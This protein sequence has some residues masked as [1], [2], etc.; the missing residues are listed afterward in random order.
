MLAN[1]PANGRKGILLLDELQ[2]FLIFPLGSQGHISLNIDM[3][4]T[5]H[6]ARRSFPFLN[7]ECARDCITAGAGIFV[8]EHD[9]CLRI[10]VDGPLRTRNHTFWFRALLARNDPGIYCSMGIG[11]SAVA[12]YAEVM[13]HLV[14]HS[15]GSVHE[16]VVV[17]TRHNA[18]FTPNASIQI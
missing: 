16:F 13:R 5:L 2:G 15:F 6:L 10:L 12:F 14:G 7:C 3:S 17:P 8:N 11:A 18:R 9:T 4:W 1:S